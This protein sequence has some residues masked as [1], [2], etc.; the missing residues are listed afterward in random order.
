M[1]VSRRVIRQ[2]RT[3]QQVLPDA[4]RTKFSVVGFRLPNHCGQSTIGFRTMKRSGARLCLISRV[5]LRRIDESKKRGRHHRSR[6][7]D[8]RPGGKNLRGGAGLL[9][10]S[11]SGTRWTTPMRAGYSQRRTRWRYSV[12]DLPKCSVIKFSS[13]GICRKFIRRKKTTGGMRKKSD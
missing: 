3:R 2:F 5:M 13:K 11:P 9:S 7:N 10:V 4:G 12:Y 1:S 6:N 8:Q